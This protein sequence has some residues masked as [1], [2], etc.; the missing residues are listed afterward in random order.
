MLAC[1]TR[2]LMTKGGIVMNKRFAKLVT[3]ITSIAILLIMENYSYYIMDYTMIQAWSVGAIGA[4]V[5]HL[6][7]DDLMTVLYESQEEAK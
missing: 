7:V 5:T 2:L 6:F 1:F 4:V 3:V